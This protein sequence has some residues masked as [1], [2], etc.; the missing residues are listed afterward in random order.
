MM[1]IGKQKKLVETKLYIRCGLVQ[2]CLVACPNNR[3]LAE[4]P[5]VKCELDYGLNATTDGGEALEVVWEKETGA[6][7]CSSPEVDG[8]RNGR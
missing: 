6:P 4:H 8:Q 7:T 1:A 2:L 5:E 3:L